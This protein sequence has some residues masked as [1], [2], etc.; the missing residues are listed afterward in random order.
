MAL[1]LLLGI[2]LIA[3]GYDL[4]QRRIPNAL[5]YAAIAAGVMVIVLVEAMLKS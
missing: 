1:V 3:A 5:T 2:G 4:R